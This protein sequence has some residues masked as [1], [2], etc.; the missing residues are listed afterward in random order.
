MISAQREATRLQS[1]DSALQDQTE[2]RRGTGEALDDEG[3]ELAYG[4]TRGAHAHDTFLFTAT[5]R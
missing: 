3:V 2:C 1:N 4:Q 5:Y